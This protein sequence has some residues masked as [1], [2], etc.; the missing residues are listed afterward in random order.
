MTFVVGCS[1]I[2]RLLANLEGDEL[3]RRRLARRVHA[4]TLID[5]EVSSVV[6]G[7]TI[8]SKPAVRISVERAEQMLMDYSDLSITRYPMQPLQP[9]VLELRHNLTAYDAMYVALAEALGL[10]LLTDDAKFAAAAGH[11]AEIHHYPN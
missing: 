10:P 5:A 9:R 4:P 1:I 3:L 11:L 2:I 8:T 6:R 7:F